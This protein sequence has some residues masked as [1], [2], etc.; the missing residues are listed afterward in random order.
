L[1][2]ITDDRLQLAELTA[3]TGDG[4]FLRNVAES[5][6]Q[7]IMA[8]DVDRL[9]GTGR[10]GRSGD[11]S[12]SCNGYPGRSLDTQLGTLNAKVP[13]LETGHSS[14]GFLEIRRPPK[15]RGHR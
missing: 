3:R 2:P 8:A 9:I 13:K 7:I 6:L 11:S 12:T 1:I 4:D 15:R 5:V 14:P 10:H